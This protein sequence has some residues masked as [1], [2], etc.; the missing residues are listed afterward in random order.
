MADCYKLFFLD[1]CRGNVT[2]EMIKR[3]PAI[4]KPIGAKGKSIGRDAIHPEHN[5]SILSSNPHK[6]PSFELVYDDIK[7]DIAWDRLTEELYKQNEDRPKCG[8]FMNAVYCIFKANAEEHN[9]CTSYSQ[10]QDE[11]I[12]RA[13]VEVPLYEDY[14]TKVGQAI[15]PCDTLKNKEKSKMCFVKRDHKEKIIIKP[16]EYLKPQGINIKQQQSSMVGYI[17]LAV[18]C[19]FIGIMIPWIT[20]NPAMLI[21]IVKL[22]SLVINLCVVVSTKYYEY[23]AKR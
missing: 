12:D 7:D 20:S 22:I 21:S 15:E 17:M 14:Q 8:I 10:I 4:N 3:S 9:Y 6:Y 2:P 16:A 18:I 13:A 1:A 19:V 11:I 5:R 23:T